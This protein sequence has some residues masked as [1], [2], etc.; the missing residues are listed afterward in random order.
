M[1]KKSHRETLLLKYGVIT[2]IFVVAFITAFQ[3]VTTQLTK[4][5]IADIYLESVDSYMNQAVDNA[6]E[7]F[8][9]QIEALELFQNSVV[10]KTTS[11]EEI[12]QAIK[13]KNKPNGF[14]YVMV[15]W[16]DA[17]GAKDGG[18]ETYNTKGGISTVGILGKEYWK[19]HKEHNARYWLETPRKSN[20]GGFTM[21]LFVES[22]FTD[23]ATG[24]KVSGGMVGF[25]ELNPINRLAT[26]FYKTGKVS[27]YDDTGTIRAGDDVLNSADKDKLLIYS[28]QCSFA[29][30]KWTVVAS[31]EFAEMHEINNTLRRNSIIGGL[32]IAV[33]LLVCILIILKIIISK[34]DS[35]KKN[36]DNLNTGDKDLTKRLPIYHNNEISQVKISVNE[37]VDNV[38]STVKNIGEANTALKVSFENVSTRLGETR[39]QI[40]NISREIAEAT[41]ML[42]KEDAC[43]DNTSTA[44]TQISSNI[45]ELNELITQQAAA[46]TEASA[47]IE[48]MIG[49]INTVSESMG[50][51][52]DEFNELNAATTEGIEKNAAVNDLLQIVLDQSKS[53]QD[54]NRIISSI[55][56]QTNLLSMNAMIE[57]AHAGIAGKGFAVVAEEIRKL[58]DTSAKQSKSIGEN[59]KMI[60]LNITKVV[61]S[62]NAS[63]ISLEKVNSKTQNTAQLVSEIKQAMDEQTEGSKQMLQVLSSMTQTSDNVLSSSREIEK[64]TNE[65]LSSVS[66]LKEASQNM[67]VNFDKIVTSADETKQT[68][69][70]LDNLSMRMA[71]AVWNISNRID[72]FKV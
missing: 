30:K 41:E 29:N 22:N 33:I 2:F 31:V 65:I 40:Q 16:D 62:A 11:R 3:I 48:E 71:V 50:R 32:I 67:S 10:S 34:F 64:G 7:W 12:K 46:I 70:Q 63:K 28:K 9:Y 24:E 17:T 14:E 39:T 53:L 18:P 66:V 20:A 42:N 1:A 52:S 27:F 19:Q 55:S 23:I 8:T 38:H 4:K 54:T 51:M 5:P 59:L 15:F 37:F 26:R 47:S 35:I 56:S 61:D 72:E 44:V 58:A 68:T 36:I 13:T 69:E 60:A 43:V 6:E 45:K 21:P 25:L 57:S 49:N